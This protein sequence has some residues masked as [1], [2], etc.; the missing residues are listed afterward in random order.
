MDREQRLDAV[1]TEYLQAAEAGRQPDETEWLA[2]HPDLAD[3]LQ[4]FL[5]TQRS[6]ERIAGPLRAPCPTPPVA[7]AEQPTLTHGET[8][9]E[10][11]AAQQ[12]FGDYE[13]LAEIARGGMGVVYRARQKS[14]NRIVAVK[15]I[16]AGQFAGAAD[17]RRFQLEA[18]AAAALDHP[19]I[20]PIYEVGMHAGQPF[21]SMKLIE[22]GSLAQASL[23][24]ERGEHSQG[25]ALP[26]LTREAR[27]RDIH[28]I[29]TVA[30]AVH[31]AHQRGILHRDLKPANILLDREG[32]P[33][34]SDFGLA[35]RLDRDAG[36][37]QSGAIVGTPS[38]MAPEQARAEKALTVAADVWALGAILYELLTGKPPF[39]AGTP[40]DTILQVI[41]REPEPPS[42]R[43]PGL[44]RDLET[45]CLKCLQKDPGKRYASAADL[46]DD[47]ARLREGRPIAARPV[48][49]VER[50]WRWCRR[51]PAVA[52]LTAAV[53]LVFLGGAIASVAF[54]LLANRRA[55]EAEAANLAKDDAL[56]Q[57]DG[58]R[59]V[60]RSEL[61]RPRDPVL[62]LLLA[63][64]G[65][66]RGRPR[67]LL[68]NNALLAAVRACNERRSFDGEYVL[69]RVRQGPASVEQHLCMR[70]AQLSADGLRLL[71][72][73]D[74]TGVPPISD[75]L[76]MLQTWE[77]PTGK[78]RHV[79]LPRFGYGIVRLSP[80]GER[81]A[82]T[83]NAYIRVRHADGRESM[84]T[85]CA[86]RIWD[87]NTGK[88]LTMLKGHDAQITSAEFSSDGKR[89]L[90]A[91]LDQTARI[92]DVAT[93]QQLQRIDTTP[94][95]LCWARFTADGQRVLTW[96][97]DRQGARGG[98]V[99][100]Q[101][102]ALV[103]PPLTLDPADKVV[104]AWGQGFHP[105]EQRE[106]PPPRLWDA[107]NGKPIATLVDAG[108]EKEPL[109][110]IAISADGRR[111]VTAPRTAEYSN[112]EIR[113]FHLWD[114][115][116]GHA[117]DNIPRM[118]ARDLV[119][120]IDRII[121]S[122]A[123]DRLLVVYRALG[124]LIA[125]PRVDQIVEVIDVGSKQMIAQRIIPVEKRQTRQE[126]EWEMHIRHAELSP[127]GKHV[128]W[129]LGNADRVSQRHWSIWFGEHKPS[130]QEGVDPVVH[131]WDIERNAMRQLVGHDN[132]VAAA[133][134][135]A[136]GRHIVTAGLE[137]NAKL[138]DV[139]GG[140]DA[141]KILDTGSDGLSVARFS[142]DGRWIAT[143]RG[144]LPFMANANPQS[145]ASKTIGPCGCGTL[146]PAGRSI[147]S[148]ALRN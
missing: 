147:S 6:V 13:L 143:A 70:N 28:W 82:V 97:V 66:E 39:Q 95:G 123:G 8:P 20:V 87:A 129:L 56:I 102:K 32:R 61:E 22:G 117:L 109:A 62:G 85:P 104:D 94:D 17:M 93:G 140:A 99:R 42:R 98:V 83:I 40:L 33:Y 108:K 76:P 115:T 47:L 27:L 41:E 119:R 64:E 112:V 72:V 44:P 35:R 45:I 71:T 3:D 58:L 55:V 80:D 113:R 4:A 74:A 92:W 48:G 96:A 124:G 50:A 118:L 89:L 110:A 69:A 126:G 141:V 135:S 23:P 79:V 88:E 120:G 21:F 127:D 68:H 1:I 100:A 116:T 145:A 10:A 78:L 5:A 59:L 101:G 60:A 132:D 14:L 91:S 77:V 114:A 37:T 57:S 81:I 106:G 43:C 26:P 67:T 19:H 52:M 103:D 128:L 16:L 51:N 137:G 25:L 146:P 65:G 134:F 122:A 142:P 30:R 46:A 11:S 15:M 90:T 105:S 18:E 84:Y 133:H 86:A 9:V 121:L 24:R 136:D 139:V 63:I 2:C 144:Q 31:F 75:V 7:Q 125:D 53:I 49:A 29:E 54:G 148:S 38:Y 130:L 34:V 111:I 12:S 73:A 138:W 131:L 107:T 36:A